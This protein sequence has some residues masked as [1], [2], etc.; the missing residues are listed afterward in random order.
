M[1]D[2]EMFIEAR[3]DK[4]KVIQEQDKVYVRVAGLA[5]ADKFSQAWIEIGPGEEPVEW[6]QA[7][8]PFTN[9]VR[10]SILADLEASLFSGSQK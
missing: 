4:I 1:A 2:P 6:K 5:D 7:S 10:N 8:S 3:I 9:P